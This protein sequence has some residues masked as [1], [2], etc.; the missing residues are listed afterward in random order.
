MVTR[1]NDHQLFR[2]IHK[3]AP[4]FQHTNSIVFSEM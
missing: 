4:K 2:V 3:P 1:N